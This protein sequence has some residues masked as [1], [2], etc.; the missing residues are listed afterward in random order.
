MEA[1]P[2]SNKAGWRAAK[3]LGNWERC[4]TNAEIIM[5]R[6]ILQQFGAKKAV[7]YMLVLRVTGVQR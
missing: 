3:S 2:C 1:D 6:F 7:R 5:Q 4:S